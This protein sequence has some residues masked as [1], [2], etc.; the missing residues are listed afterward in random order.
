MRRLQKIIE[1]NKN[2]SQTVKITNR[3]YKHNNINTI[4]NTNSRLEKIQTYYLLKQREE[5]I[6]FWTEYELLLFYYKAKARTFTTLR[7][8]M[9]LAFTERIEKEA[10]L[11]AIK[12]LKST[13][14]I[15]I[16]P[17]YKDDENQTQSQLD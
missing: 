7:S 6:D 1:N 16:I 10:K 17:V 11:R 8:E 2:S 3:S 12:H 14:N 13:I 4:N 5:E 9:Y 15:G